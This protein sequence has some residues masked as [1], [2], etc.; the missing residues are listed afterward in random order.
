PQGSAGDEGDGNRDRSGEG[1]VRFSQPVNSTK[2]SSSAWWALPDDREW[3]IVFGRAV[4][5]GGALFS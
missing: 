5:R 4:G 1:I 2:R 3:S